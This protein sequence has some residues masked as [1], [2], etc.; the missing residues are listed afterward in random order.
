M[1]LL[2][3]PPPQTVPRSIREQ[4]TFFLLIVFIVAFKCNDALSHPQFW[5]EDANVFFSG[6]FGQTWPQLFSPYAGYLHTLP[7]LAAWI[8]SWLPPGKAPLI[9]NSVAVLLTAGAITTTCMRLR[10]HLPA[11]VVALSFL[12]VPTSGEIFGTIT[13]AQWFLQFSMAAY[14]LAPVRQPT[15]TGVPWLRALCMF[16]I[17]LTGPFSILLLIVVVGI[18]ATS[19]L[20]V[21]VHR[22]PFNGALSGFIGSRDRHAVWPMV[23]GA[24]IQTCVLVAYPPDQH[25]VAQPLLAAFKA[26]FTE[27]VPIHT[28]GSDF[29]TGKSWFLIYGLVLAALV[30]SRR[31][32][33]HARLLVLGFLAFAAIECLAPMLRVPDLG[34]MYVLGAADRYFY[35]IKVV[36]W[37]AVWLTLCQGSRRSRLNA[38][39]ITAGLI[40]LFAVVNAGYLRRGAFIDFNWRGHAAAL[41][42]PGQHTIPVN[43]TGWSVNVETAAKES[44]P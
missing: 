43:P 6:Q 7:R 37:W 12:L 35:L 42:Q 15:S 34:P 18:C 1:P 24:L 31:V 14:C 28:F 9:Y 40:C 17:A 5:A 3:N 4:T 8:A 36:W 13:N 10:A 39:V 33:G 25:E 20:S 2:S 19:W 22:D 29:M 16:L 30:W 27:I 44:K 23:A 38:T 41:D 26:T 32:D 21:R 11:G